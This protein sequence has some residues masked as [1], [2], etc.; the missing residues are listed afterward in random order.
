MMATFTRLDKA[1]DLDFDVLIVESIISKNRRDL[2][3]QLV[4]DSFHL[5]LWLVAHVWA[6]FSILGPGPQIPSFRLANIQRLGIQDRISLSRSLKDGTLY[7]CHLHESS[8]HPL[9]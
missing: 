7:I 5:E 4:I 3:S 1:F 6:K 2:R 8:L 9:N